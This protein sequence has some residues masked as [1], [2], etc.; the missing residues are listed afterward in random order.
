MSKSLTISVDAMSGDRGPAP[1]VDAACAL[2]DEQPDLHIILVGDE[3]QLSTLVGNTRCGAGDRLR[4][5]HTT[6][7]VTMDESPRNAVRCKKQSSM[8][9]AV[10]AVKS[11]EADACVSAGNTGALMAIARFVLRTLP[12]ISRPAIIS[13]VP[14]RGGQ[15]CML[16]LGANA[17]CSARQLFEFA[18]MGTVVVSDI[19]AID[20]PRV[21]L[22]NI[23]EEQIKGTDTIREAAV[24]L[25]KSSL[26][27][28]GFVEGDDIFSG[29]ADVVVSD[30]FTGN[31]A[32]KT[33]EGLAHFMAAQTRARFERNWLTRLAGL[34]A[35][36][37]LRSLRESLDPR[38]Y[39]GASL[40]GL[41]GIVIKSH[42]SADSVA[43]QT[44]IR[45]AI[46]EVRKG[47][48][49]QISRLLETQLSKLQAP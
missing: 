48:P 1:A 34:A 28:V 39:N 21:G 32:L 13:A 19:F 43:W 15:T 31:V 26:N 38:R 14:A 49:V 37:V 42:G 40:V 36:P 12:G 47:V 24:L 29:C 8:R 22:L 7:V 45:A 5:R 30:G 2:L 11:G 9:I 33:M 10:D 23:G 46:L 44:A 20:R 3:A 4:L 18:V 17:D 25:E 41:N 35:L 27:Y 16:D 6:D